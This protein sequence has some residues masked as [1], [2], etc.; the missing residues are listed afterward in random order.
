[1]IKTQYSI[2]YLNVKN[3]LKS[4]KKDVSENLSDALMAQDGK[5]ADVVF[6]LLKF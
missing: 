6:E 2:D 1:M 5:L 3:I 4:I